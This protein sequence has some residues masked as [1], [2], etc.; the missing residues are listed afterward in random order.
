[1]QADKEAF[2]ERAEA[3]AQLLEER[4]KALKKKAREMADEEFGVE[5]DGGEE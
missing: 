5:R 2:E 3:K 1:M 4:D